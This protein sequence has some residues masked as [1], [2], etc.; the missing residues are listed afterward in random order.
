[1]KA[2]FVTQYTLNQL[3]LSPALL[4]VISPATNN[5][6]N[7]TIYQLSM[8]VKWSKHEVDHSPLFSAAV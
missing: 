2:T 6:T 8:M 7:L 3:P 1:M 4:L 5:V